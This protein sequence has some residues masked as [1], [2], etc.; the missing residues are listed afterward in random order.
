MAN[1][2]PARGFFFCVVQQRVGGVVAKQNNNPRPA[3]DQMPA[4]PLTLTPNT[5]APLVER[6]EW[7]T[8][9][10]I[11]R[12][13]KE[14]RT[15]LRAM[16]RRG[17][18]IETIADRETMANLRLSDTYTLPD[19]H[20]LIPGGDYELLSANL[21]AEHLRATGS[22]PL[23]SLEL[24]LKANTEAVPA[25]QS[26]PAYDYAPAEF[27]DRIYGQNF[28]ESVA[29]SVREFD[30]GHLRSRL[31]RHKKRSL[32]AKVQLFGEAEIATFRSFL[33]AVQGRWGAISLAHPVDDGRTALWRLAHDA[34]AL[35]Y[36]T[37]RVVETELRL[38]ELA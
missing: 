2:S 6:L 8:D 36:H 33:H 18:S 15:P 5:A 30:E 31:L 34:V 4:I 25:Y 24:L 23:L 16:P 32:S 35:T 7:L 37:K 20:W 14:L 38:V 27:P 10:Q 21:E 1:E 12:N 3:A 11:S 19:D 13:G 17:F 29:W 28:N 9:V 26:L 22:A